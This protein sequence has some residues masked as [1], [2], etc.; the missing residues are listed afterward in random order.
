MPP[1]W[2]F[3]LTPSKLFHSISPGG[4]KLNGVYD[5]RYP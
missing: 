4:E 3:T 5:G 2:H 1:N